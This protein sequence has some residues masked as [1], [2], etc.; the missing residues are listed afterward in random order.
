MAISGFLDVFIV[1][2][3]AL[4]AI[5]G[6]RIGFVARSLSWVGLL[7]GLSAAVIGLPYLLRSVDHLTSLSRLAVVSSL[8]LAGALLGQMV[9]LIA[10]SK[11]SSVV[12]QGLA[13]SGDRVAGAFAGGFGVLVMVWLMLP[14]AAEVPG[15]SSQQVRSSRIA[16]AV[17]DDAPPAPDAMKTL[18]RLVGDEN[19]PS[20]FEG[21]APAPDAGPP[22]PEVSLDPSAVTRVRAASVKV[23]G[24]ACNRSQDGS[25][26]VVARGLV[27]TNAHVVA[28]ETSTRVVTSGG[29]ELDAEVVLFDAAR[30][31]ALLRVPRLTADPLPIGDAAIGEIGAVFGHP[32]GQDA[33]AI[34]PAAIRR[35]ITAVG[36]DLYDVASTRRDVLIL[37]AE[38]QPGD[39]G[40]ALVNS[41]GEVIG[42]AFAIA[43]DKS[44]TAYALNTSELHAVLEQPYNRQVSTGPCLND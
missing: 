8:M 3:A 20:V 2:T 43:P 39:S 22:P 36:R 10:G 14:T 23:E 37:A 30:D 42:V 9:G 33:L 29:V 18:R 1:L 26:F 16:Q 24:L 7:V 13:R 11:L 4:A 12:P 44:D 34:H 19:F 40:G 35:Q 31:L 6:Y 5:G 15:W 41:Q 28:G 21:L 27:V 25:G 32:N 38:L 17:Y